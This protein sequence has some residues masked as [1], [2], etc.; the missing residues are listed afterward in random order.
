[1]KIIV[2][3]LSKKYAAFCTFETFGINGVGLGTLVFQNQLKETCPYPGLYEYWFTP[4]IPQNETEILM[5]QMIAG[6]LAVAFL[7]QASINFD[8]D[9]PKRTKLSCVYTFGACDWLWVYIITQHMSLISL[10]HILG[11]IAVVYIRFF[12]MI[13]PSI[14]F[15]DDDEYTFENQK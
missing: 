14:M 2:P 7:L 15:S 5:S 12:F 10:Y 13:N 6:W 4:P 3:G 8:K 1:M 11:T 9:V